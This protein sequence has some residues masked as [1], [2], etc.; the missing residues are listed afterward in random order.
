MKEGRRISSE[1]WPDPTN[2]NTVMYDAM[3]KL[4]RHSLRGSHL[5]TD[6]WR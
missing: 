1:G 6:W 4:A 3:S 5:V 2:S